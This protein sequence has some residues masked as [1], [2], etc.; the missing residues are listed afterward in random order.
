MRR[1]EGLN[2]EDLVSIKLPF[3]L[4]HLLY[5]PMGCKAMVAGI[6]LV[7][8]QGNINELSEELGD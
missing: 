6:S 7:D 5:V 3:P 2:E 8:I 4:P 1:P